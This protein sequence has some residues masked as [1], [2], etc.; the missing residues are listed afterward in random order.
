MYVGNEEYEIN[1]GSIKGTFNKNDLLEL[2]SEVLL[3]KDHDL[4]NEIA[5]ILPFNKIDYDT[6]VEYGYMEGY[7]DS[8]GTE[9]DYDEGYTSGNHEAVEQCI[10]QKEQLRKDL[11]ES[12]NKIMRG[13]S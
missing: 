2:V 9:Y 5:N 3:F 1:I 8:P 12:F 11:V 13:W 4:Q 6:G 7:D 10:R